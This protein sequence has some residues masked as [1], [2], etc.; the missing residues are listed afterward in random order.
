MPYALG[1]HDREATFHANYDPYTSSLL[2]W[3]T[4]RPF[5]DTAFLASGGLDYAADMFRTVEQR[6][7]GVF[8]LDGLVEIGDGRVPPPDVL[9][10]DTQGTERAIVAGA[11][12]VLGGTVAV[13]SEVIF[14]DLYAGQDTFHTLHSELR[15]AGFAFIRFEHL[16]GF[17]PVRLPVGFRS[18]P[19]HTQADALFLRP[20]TFF[21]PD[22][23][24]LIKLAFVAHVLGEHAIGFAAMARGATTEADDA[25]A[26]RRFVHALNRA[27]Q[28]MP[29]IYPPTFTDL[30]PS[31]EASALRFDS[32]QRDVFMQRREAVIAPLRARM[33]ERQADLV[34]LF[35]ARS[36]PIEDVFRA[37]DLNERADALAER[38]KA[39]VTALLGQLDLGVQRKE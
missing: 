11:R 22:D 8:R 2:P 27:A 24:Q 6:P 33:I 19:M 5:V 10:L 17:E 38:R 1:E 14:D 32:A 37:W 23:P 34:M 12:G 35:A 9:T 21:A 7:I 20:P 39:D 29:A 30:Y 18:A 4:T 16:G 15:A 31:A 36:T 25:L 28:A 26:Y 3:S 13:R